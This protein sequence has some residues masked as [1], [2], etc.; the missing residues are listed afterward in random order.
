MNPQ[1]PIPAALPPETNAPQPDATVPLPLR[2]PRRSPRRKP[3]TPR[4]TALL[5][6]KRRLSWAQLKALLDARLGRLDPATLKQVLIACG[7]AVA[8]AT[9]IIALCQFVPVGLALLVVLGLGLVLQF[10][11]EIRRVL[12]FA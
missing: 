10:W 4:R 6:I 9:V 8:A 5:P 1:N 7:I 3:R 11:K 2:R 12:T